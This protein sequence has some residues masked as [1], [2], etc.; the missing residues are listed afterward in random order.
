MTS[1]ESNRAAWLVAER[2]NPLEVSAGP[3]QTN[4]VGDEVIIHVAAVAINPSEPYM[5]A[6]PML[7][8]N[9]PHV[10][11]SDVAGTVAKI[12]SEVTRFK[13]GDRVIGHCLGL[14]HGGARHGGFQNFTTCREAAVAKIPDSLPFEQAA[15]LPL[16]ISTSATALYDQLKLRLPTVE[17]T[18][19]GNEAVLIWGGAT[20]IGSSAI[21]FAVAS[22]YRVVTAASAKSHGYVEALVPTGKEDLKIFDY[23]DPDAAAKI[24][25]YMDDSGLRFAGAYDCITREPTLRVVADVVGHFG[26]GT[27]STV[28]PGAESPREDVKLQLVWSTNAAMLP[29]GGAKVWRDFVPQALEKGTFVAQ[30]KAQ[31]VGQG[32]E[33]IQSAIDL[34]TKGVS[35]TKLVVVL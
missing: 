22:G 4:P 33:K 13:L 19:A 5:Q 27:I 31:V 29:D 32:L 25:S 2:A 7:P 14:I 30:P 3:D 23:A 18:K 10:L 8:L 1:I 17:P 9:Y 12:G 11:G 15:V 6:D 24:I 28:L 20:S 34:Y 21:Q 26:G 16:S 35:A